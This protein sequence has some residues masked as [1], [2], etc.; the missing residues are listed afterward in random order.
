[1]MNVLQ[2]ASRLFKS[3]AKQHILKISYKKSERARFMTITK[4]VTK[5]RRLIMTIY[6]F[7]HEDGV[8]VRYGVSVK[9]GKHW[10]MENLHS[11]D[12][13]SDGA[14][15]GLSDDAIKRIKGL[16]GYTLQNKHI[17]SKTPANVLVEAYSG[18]LIEHLDSLTAY[19]ISEEKGN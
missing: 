3:V 11:F 19:A 15:P 12:D 17:T 16:I 6:H 1:M 8:S 5:E 4:N 14:L 10:T 7:L 13:V 2:I 18:I 9:K